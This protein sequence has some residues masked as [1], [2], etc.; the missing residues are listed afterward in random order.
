M[1]YPDRKEQAL[2]I[3]RDEKDPPLLDSH[4]P[5]IHKWGS[6]LNWTF[7]PCITYAALNNP[8]NHGMLSLFGPGRYSAVIV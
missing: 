6:V 3:S 1:P 8:V 4:T 7:F 2:P 5:G